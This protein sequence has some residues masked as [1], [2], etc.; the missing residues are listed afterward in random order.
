MVMF[1]IATLTLV[2][3]MVDDL[4]SR[5]VHNALVLVLLPIVAFSSLYFRGIDGTLIGIGAMLLALILTIPLFVVRII[6]GGDV[7][8]FGVFALAVDPLSMFWTLIYSFFWGGLF[9]MTRAVLSRQLL[10]LVRN[11][12]K[13]ASRQKIQSQEIHKIPYTFALLLGWLTQLTF[14]RVAGLL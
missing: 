12:T 9:G 3:G 4:R 10:A 2:A 1:G 8:L 7:K 13:A 11:T 6:G 14:M 5:K